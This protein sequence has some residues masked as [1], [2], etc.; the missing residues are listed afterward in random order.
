[1]SSLGLHMSTS[2][3]RWMPEPLLFALQLLQ[4]YHEQSTQA[5]VSAR[6]W[7]VNL[8]TDNGLLASADAVPLTLDAHTRGDISEAQLCT[9]CLSAAAGLIARSA[10]VHADLPSFPEVFAPALTVLREL[11][12]MPQGLL[13]VHSPTFLQSLS[14]CMPQGLPVLHNPRFLQSLSLCV[15]R[16]CASWCPEAVKA[17]IVQKPWV[18][19]EEDIAWDSLLNTAL[20]NKV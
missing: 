5:S 9:S 17:C 8:S 14:L 20:S 13:V 12:S 6:G 4:T 2:A 19:Q 18:M 15:S 16:P 1:M 10:E 7:T 3:A 11:H